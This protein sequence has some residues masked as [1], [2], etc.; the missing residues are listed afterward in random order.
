M[1]KSDDARIEGD[2]VDIAP[3][4]GGVLTELLVREGQPVKKGQELFQL[5]SD[6]VEATLAKMEADVG[7]ARSGIV[8]AQAQYEKAVNGS[9]PREIQIAE[10]E[11]HRAET[12]ENLAGA[13]WKRTN[14]LFETQAI[15]EAERDRSKAEWGDRQTG[16]GSG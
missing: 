3:Q 12:A 9:R 16:V 13:N 4:I 11:L 2:L 1:V 14:A 10:S 8:L 5:D 7:S 15:T 6:A